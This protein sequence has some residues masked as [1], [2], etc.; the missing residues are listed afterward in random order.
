[1][2]L[3]VFTEIGVQSPL[4]KIYLEVIYKTLRRFPASIR[5]RVF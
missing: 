3:D 5:T 2:V 4:V 1:M